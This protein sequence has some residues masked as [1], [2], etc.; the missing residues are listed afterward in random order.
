[1]LCLLLLPSR[2]AFFL[3]LILH[4]VFSLARF[5]FSCFFIRGLRF[6]QR[7]SAFFFPALLGF[8]GFV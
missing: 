6:I 5:R 2:F 7:A 4:L 8:L 1:M 3:L